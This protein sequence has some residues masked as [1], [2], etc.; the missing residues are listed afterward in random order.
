MTLNTVLP[1][2][3]IS[4]PLAR[5]LVAGFKILRFVQNDKKPMIRKRVIGFLRLGF[6]HTTARHTVWSLPLSPKRSARTAFSAVQPF[7]CVKGWTQRQSPVL[8]DVRYVR[9]RGRPLLPFVRR[10]PPQEQG[11]GAPPPRL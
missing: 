2:C 5:S 9:A 10:P 3:M 6:F 4:A 7:A 1:V 8:E 11:T